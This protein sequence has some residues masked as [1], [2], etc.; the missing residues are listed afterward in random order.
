MFFVGKFGKTGLGSRVRGRSTSCRYRIAWSVVRPM[1]IRSGIR[2]TRPSC[3][4][5]KC[6]WPC[7]AP[8]WSASG[9]APLFNHLFK[10]NKKQKKHKKHK[11]HHRQLDIHFTFSTF[12]VHFINQTLELQMHLHSYTKPSLPATS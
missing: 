7:R 4:R 11:N 2:R 5:R 6:R 10:K 9:T 3:K 1:C 8:S 12:H